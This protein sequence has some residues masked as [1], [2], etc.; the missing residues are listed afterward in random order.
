M[1]I[2]VLGVLL[3]VSCTGARPNLATCLR[4]LGSLYTFVLGVGNM[5]EVDVM[6]L[7]A[8]F[9]ARG[10]ETGDPGVLASGRVGL[11]G[12]VSAVM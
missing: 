1:C 5:A 11:A 8:G 2:F 7:G 3:G 6:G 10:R 12:G 9:G 4:T